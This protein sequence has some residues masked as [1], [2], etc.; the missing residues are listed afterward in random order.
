VEEFV[1]ALSNWFGDDDR[2]GDPP[3]D[4]MVA[5][6]PKLSGR[7]R[8]RDSDQVCARPSSV[9]HLALASHL[10]S[11]SR[12]ANLSTSTSSPSSR[13]RNSTN[14]PMVF[15]ESVCDWRAG[16]AAVATTNVTP[17]LAVEQYQR[18]VSHERRNA[19]E[20]LFVDTAANPQVQLAAIAQTRDALAQT[21]FVCSLTYARPAWTREL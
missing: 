2:D 9:H 15:N 3:D 12:N 1:T 19:M 18:S 14:C 20:D 13:K 21:Q 11:P 7:K 8:P 4:R 17:L 16:G 5:A 6:T 10:L